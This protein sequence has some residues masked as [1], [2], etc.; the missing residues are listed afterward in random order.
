[1]ADLDDLIAQARLQTHLGTGEYTDAEITKFLNRGIAVI[2]S[3]FD[4]PW[5]DATT[6]FDSVVGTMAYNVPADHVKTYSITEDGESVRLRAITQDQA[7][8][9]Y[10]DDPPTR[11]PRAF[12]IFNGQY[13]FQEKP[14]AV[15]TYNVYYKAEPSTLSAGTDVP[16]WNSLHHDFL[17]D[18]A[19]S[20][21]WEAE[22]DRQLSGDALGRFEQGM[23]DLANFYIHEASAH[24]IVWGERSDRVVGGNRGN[25]PWLDGA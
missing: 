17:A 9:R 6:T 2:A 7:Y 18:Y 19:I 3:R 8:Q 25:M 24:P 4:W 21:L 15:K 13:V 20:K 10:G 22:E 5:L 23:A 14:S 16:D 11:D 12:Y 1:M